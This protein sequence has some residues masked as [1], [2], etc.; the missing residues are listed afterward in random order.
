MNQTKG[1]YY[2]VPIIA[3]LVSSLSIL[4]GFILLL[5]SIYSFV[6]FSDP[7]MLLPS[8]FGI[9]F[10][11]VGYFLYKGRNWARF[12]EILLL[13]GLS[14][15]SLVATKVP[16]LGEVI[17]KIMYI[18]GLLLLPLPILGISLIVIL[19]LVLHK[20]TAQYFKYLEEV[21]TISFKINKDK[22][23]EN[24]PEQTL[25][26]RPSS[27]STYG[28]TQSMSG[29][30][31][32]NPTPT[33]SYKRTGDP[34][35]ET[36]LRDGLRRPGMQTPGAARPQDDKTVVG[37]KIE[38]AASPSYILYH[39]KETIRVVNEIY[40]IFGRE[41]FERFVTP[42][43]AQSISRNANG[44]HFRITMSLSQENDKIKYFVED[45][46]SSNGTLVNGNEIKRKGK[47]PLN[48]SDVITIG[49]TVKVE[50]KTL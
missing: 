17:G 15:V 40:R 14:I 47:V 43:E 39:P 48:H 46:D 11:I 6:V 12:G 37:K 10:I 4:V 32:I 8:I 3:T 24:M 26:S 42:L 41:D 13:V 36:M 28:G 7:V 16:Q 25:Y 33:Q 23:T 34:Y 50:F 49:K 30:I 29:G 18:G 31:R 2:R 27:A 44:G 22:R 9:L 21:G 45:L 1:R 5:A 20:G 38:T 19:L 35:G